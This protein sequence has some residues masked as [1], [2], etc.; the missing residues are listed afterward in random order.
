MKVTKMRGKSLIFEILTLEYA[1]FSTSTLG[2]VAFDFEQKIELEKEAKK[3][4]EEEE[5]KE[6]EAKQQAAAENR[7]YEPT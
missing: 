3:K 6:A 5:K 2:P 1:I 4:E 7:P